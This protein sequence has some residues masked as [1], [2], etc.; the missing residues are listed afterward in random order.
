MRLIPD[1]AVIC[2]LCVCAA[3]PL[4][5]SIGKRRTV[6]E[7]KVFDLVGRQTGWAATNTALYWTNDNG[8][9]WKNIAPPEAKEGG[10]VN[11]FFVDATHGWVLLLDPTAPNEN[12]EFRLSITR[13]GGNSWTTKKLVLPPHQNWLS[14]SA[15]LFF[16]DADHG[17]ANILVSSGAQF[18]PG[19]L[20]QTSDG[21]KT[22][23]QVSRHGIDYGEIRFTSLNQGWIAGGPGGH[24]L[25][26]TRDGGKN[27]EQISLPHP[28]VQN[29]QRTRNIRCPSLRVINAAI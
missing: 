16:L 17:W 2:L 25:Y 6:T 15:T 29:L 11:A 27:W 12:A 14:Q 8:S 1:A 7:I 9:S 13:D 10:I 5:V 4:Q 21:G 22:W 3:L 20:L 26:N 19:L 24:F 28:K 23:N 18:L